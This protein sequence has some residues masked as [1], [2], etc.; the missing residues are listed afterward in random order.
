MSTFAQAFNKITN[1]T[2]TENGAVVNQS[3]GNLVLDFSHKVVR[4][5]TNDEIK[6]RIE[7]IIKYV[8]TTNNVNELH[9]LF[10]L[11]F[12]KRNTRGGEGEKLITYHM[13]LELYNHYPNTII[14]LMS[15]LADFGY[16]KDFYQI[17]ETISSLVTNEVEKVEG[18]EKIRVIEHYF[19]KYNALIEEIIK[20]TIMQRNKD[21]TVISENGK[22]IS[23]IGKWIPREGS[24]F[25]KKCDWFQRNDENILVTRSL[26]DMMVYELANVN[27]VVLDVNRKYPSYWYKTYR[28]GNVQLT[29]KLDVLEIAM[30]A[31]SYS[32]IKFE[33]V[34]SRAMVKYRK[35]FMNEKLKEVPKPYQETT[36]NRFPDNVDR[37]QARKNLKAVLEGK[38]AS[39]LK[40]TNME[41]HEILTKLMSHSLSSMEEEVLTTMW[42][43]K[44]TDVKKHITEVLENMKTLGQDTGSNSGPGKV[45]PMV[46]VSGSMMSSYNNN[47][48]PLSVAISMGIMTA[49]LHE[50]DSPFKDTLISFTDVPKNFK[51][52]PEQTLKQ[53]YNVVNSYVGYNTNFRLAMETLLKMCIVNNVKEDDIPDLLVFTDGQ[54]DA[55]GYSYHQ[56]QKQWT[57]HH[58]ELMKL[59]ATGGYGKIPRIIY[60]N[61]RAGTPG[62]QTDANHPGVQMLQ[63]FSP[64][65]IKFILYGESFGEK[66]QEIEVDGKIIKMKVSQVTPLETFRAII[67]Q[68]KYDIV[69]CILDDTNEKLLSSYSFRPVLTDPEIKGVSVD[70]EDVNGVKEVKDT[71][72]DKKIDNEY[73]LV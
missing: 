73:E 66:T 2:S 16:Y 44:K 17:W 40:A 62:V 42:E 10:V 53:R 67:D 61:L 15:L 22:S 5:T 33:Q 68:S 1:K 52:T 29:K 37:V 36:G 48:T 18:S 46:D 70:T 58:E 19:N 55:W 4:G 20:H 26:I 6:T 35:A 7:E 28:A 63:G 30:C 60:W 14:K 8:N 51:F 72:D 69:R 71:K 21:L 54:F 23:L 59:W 50:N 57:T 49:E 32:D 64:N 43:N 41:P 27:N 24:H 13:V 3:T 34:T 39:K 25:A 47:P 9:D 38:L 31:G 45:I 11:M 56:A 12:H 65:L